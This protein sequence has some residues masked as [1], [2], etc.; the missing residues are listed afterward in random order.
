MEHLFKAG[1]RRASHDPRSAL[2]DLRSQLPVQ[3]GVVFDLS[4]LV[5]I[6]L[7][8]LCVLRGNRATTTCA[9]RLCS[10]V[11]MDTG[12][13]VAWKQSASFPKQH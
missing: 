10:L 8:R 13:L 11:T 9:C 3:L 5:V 1:A 4:S 7:T 6:F 2:R 12:S